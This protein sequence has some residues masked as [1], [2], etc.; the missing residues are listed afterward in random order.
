MKTGSPTYNDE[1]QI[2]AP[3]SRADERTLVLKHGHT[4]ALFDR[5]GDV[6]HAGLGEQGVYHEGTRFLSRLELQIY[7]HRPL[8][9][10]STVKEDNSLLTADLTN[11]DL[12]QGGQ[13]T[14]PRG[15]LHIFRGKLLWQGACYEHVRV[16]N[17][18]TTELE[19]VLGFE[20]A[21]DYADIFEVRGVK[22]SRRGIRL[23]T[24][25]E[26]HEAVLAYQGLDEVMRRTR[27]V[28]SLAPTEIS[29]SHTV[30]RL[31]LPPQEEVS[32]YM[33]VSCEFG[34]EER[35]LTNYEYALRAV[36][37]ASNAALERRC[38]I[39]SSNEPFNDWINR[40]SAD[41]HMLISELPEGAYP[42]AG[43]PWFSTPFGRDGL[44][45]AL[46]YLWVDPGL[47]KGV[48]AFLAA[49]QAAHENP[50]QDAEPGKIL[51]E[52]RR[53]EMAALGEI[54]FGCYYGSV[55]S[56]PLFVVL[57]GAYYQRTGDR[58]FIEA[59]WPNIERALGWIEL[60]GD[61]DGDGFVEYARHSTHGLVHQGWKDSREPVFHADG[62]SAEGPI[63]LCEVQGYVYEAKLYAA[64]FAEMFG[65][66]TRAQ[67]LRNDAEQ[68][69]ARFNQAYWC[70]DIAT[71]AIALDGA[72][73]PCEVRSSNAGHAL[74]SGIA[75]PEYARRIAETLL[76]DES[77]S[78][79]GVRTIAR[80]APRFNPMS[81]HNGSIWPH[82]NALIGMGLA[83]YGYKQ[84]ALKILEAQFDASIFT[85]LHRL[86][87]LFCGFVR[88]PGE[89]PTLYPVACS[90]QA[91][92]SATAFYLLQ[93]CLG[94]SF[95][96]DKPQVWF[97][98]PVLPDFVQRMKITNLRV[99]DAVADL[100]LHRHEHDVSI[101]VAR[102]EGDMGIR[103]LV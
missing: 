3:S 94:L 54:P 64:Q 75:E 52:A 16:I 35:V 61:V 92:A 101:N 63:A 84:E 93:A 98:H 96:P 99:G 20:Y 44:I 48:L 26:E 12:Y 33:T 80:N 29:G 36:G 76:C 95:H 5:H 31:R 13:L 57:A 49:T 86:P 30:F 87:E 42:F 7:G 60:Y 6:T 103:V 81:Y 58:A 45:T 90:P 18:G 4:F 14:I 78:G 59:I 34:Y 17:Y 69:K 28:F 67:A 51:H 19:F 82:D 27:L 83:R 73:Q 50:E 66:S 55:D 38:S 68:L 24:V 23:D 39:V 62:R 40:S 72:K 46:E 11:P 43:V 8:L 100:T 74:F 2:V 56:T 1:W 102:K 70:D 37:A 89:G 88:R 47:A 85:D 10:K 41:L 15:T 22:R 21:A 9:L 65:D 25:V 77:F 91:W 32:L 71:Y 97:E 79:W 53:G